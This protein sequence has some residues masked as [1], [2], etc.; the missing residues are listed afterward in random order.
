MVV[1]PKV[2]EVSACKV[3]LDC[4]LVSAAPKEKTARVF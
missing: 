4:A 3:A 2:L 1:S